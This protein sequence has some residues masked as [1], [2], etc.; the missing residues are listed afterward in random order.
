MQFDPSVFCGC[1]V[2]SSLMMTN[3]DEMVTAAGTTL[4]LIEHLQNET[5]LWE[6]LLTVPQLFYN[7]SVDQALLNTEVLLSNIQ[8]WSIVLKDALQRRLV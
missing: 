3:P 2:L 7:G 8:G 4:M 6:T 5:T 1:Q